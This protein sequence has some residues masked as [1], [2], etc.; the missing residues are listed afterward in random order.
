MTLSLLEMAGVTLELLPTR[1]PKHDLYVDNAS[2]YAN[3]LSLLQTDSEFLESNKPCLFPAE[4]QF[5]TQNTGKGLALS[6]Y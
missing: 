6:K 3:S 5:R 2:R 1:L 4:P